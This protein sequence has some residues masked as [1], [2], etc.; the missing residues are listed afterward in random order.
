[1]SSYADPRDRLVADVRILL[2]DTEELLAAV[3]A[4]SK[5]KLAGIRPRLEASI[6]RARS[7]AA[8]VQE[9]K[10]P[11][12]LDEP[13]HVPDGVA[14]GIFGAARVALDDE[15]SAMNTSRGVGLVER[16]ADSEVLLVDGERLCR[17]FHADEKGILDGEEHE[18]EREIHAARPGDAISSRR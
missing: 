5:E 3:G 16:E 17:A 7:R 14:H 18:E 9:Q 8:E 1:M 4:E 2:S 15:T 11:V 12:L 10:D 6:Q 13:L